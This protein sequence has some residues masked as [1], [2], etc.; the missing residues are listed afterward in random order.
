MSAN[1]ELKRRMAELDLTQVELAHKMN[2][3]VEHLT[4]RYGTFQERTIYNLISG[5]TRR[6]QGKTRAALEAVF[7]CR[8]EDLGFN[9]QLSPED[10]VRRR[11]FLTS[12]TGVT[13][14][15]AVPPITP[16][17]TVGMS[18][19]QRL[20]TGLEALEAVNDHKGGHVALE[21]AALAGCRNALDAQH[22]SASER[23][24]KHLFSL[25]AAYSSNA[26]WSCIDTRDLERAQTHL[27]QAMTYAGLAQDTTAELCVWNGVAV[28]ANQQRNYSEAVAAAQAAQTTAITRRDPF[29]ASL[30]HIRLALGYAHLGDRTAAL[31]SIGHAQDA[32]TR[33]DSFLPR[34]RWTAFYGQAELDALAAIVH[35][36][37]G[38]PEHSEA[39][40]HRALAA[41][42]R[43]FR[44][45]RA[46]AT[47]E[48][49]LAQL[50]QGEAEHACATASNVFTIMEGTPL[51]VR[52]RTLIGD[53]HRG[54]FTLA[55]SASCAR[56]WGDRMRTEWS[57]V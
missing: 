23:V 16:R 34:P 13:A 24:R 40:S 54:L 25:A 57:R 14:A 19:V 3:A 46:L 37:T 9:S 39:I 35:N 6:P 38:A 51:P 29:F 50:H 11:T 53:F 48:L 31:R 4:G 28:L 27:N 33:A 8:V 45:N 41:I 21:N 49:A 15:A 52:M 43:Q 22:G 56:E 1:E 10:P 32:L 30:A 12:T 44:R 5:V 26:A 36:L 2:A 42:P 17:R 18:D 55:P 7:G 47:A 20:H